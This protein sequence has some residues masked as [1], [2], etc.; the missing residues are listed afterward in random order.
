MKAKRLNNI[1]DSK[2]NAIAIVLAAG[3]GK[4]MGGKLPK[5]YAEVEGRTVLSYTLEKF[6]KHPEIGAVIVVCGRGYKKKI[7]AICKEHGFSKV[8]PAV[9]GGADRRESSE[10]GVLYAEKLAADPRFGGNGT[11]EECIVLIH[12][13]VRPNVSDRII[14]DNIRL[15]KKYGACVTAARSIDTVIVSESGE[16]V[17]GTLPR[18]KLWNVQTPQSFRLGVIAAAHRF[19]NGHK[20]GGELPEITD[21]GGLVRFMGGTVAICESDRDNLKLTLPEDMIVFRENVRRS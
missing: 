11:P 3:C 21:D 10:T 2:E 14:S 18:S 19:Y 12:D 13:G 4:R 16:T 5:Q 15:A 7:D 9:F 17:D 6:E 1:D 8:K 20:A